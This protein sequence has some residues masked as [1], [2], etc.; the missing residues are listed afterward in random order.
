[1]IYVSVSLSNDVQGYGQCVRLLLD[2]GAATEMLSGGLRMSA[3]HLAAQVKFYIQPLE[4]VILPAAPPK[5][6][7][8]YGVSHFMV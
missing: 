3:L 5:S 8:C 4:Y 2:W 7:L 1:M 6:P